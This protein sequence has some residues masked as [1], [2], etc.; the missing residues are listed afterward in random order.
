MEEYMANYYAA[1]RQFKDDTKNGF[2]ADINMVYTEEINPKNAM[3]PIYKNEW[4]FYRHKKDG[5]PVPDKFKLPQK[6][7]L[8]CK[9]IK[10]I[11][12]DFYTQETGQWIISDD[13]LEFIQTNKAF[14]GYYELSELTILTNKEEKIGNKKYYLMRFFKYDDEIIQWENC[15]KITVKHGI[16][17]NVYSELN[18]KENIESPLF[19]IFS[20]PSFKHAFI[21]EEEMKNKMAEKNLLGFNFYTLEEYMKESVKRIEYFK[22]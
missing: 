5:I 17:Y 20:I 22:K 6:L 12:F 4:L 21:A 18:F 13:F 9:S 2:P 14:A 7:F 11:S 10:K 1:L 19:L 15:N 3:N 16:E 8:I